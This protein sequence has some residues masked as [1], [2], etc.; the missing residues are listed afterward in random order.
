MTDDRNSGAGRRAISAKFST[1]TLDS[2]V[3]SS[4]PLRKYTVNDTG[5]GGMD[6]SAAPNDRC[7]SDAWSVLFA[8]GHWGAIGRKHK[9]VEQR[10]GTFLLHRHCAGLAIGARQ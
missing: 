5:A 8:G 4:L 6:A 9:G 7:T 10:L 1:S 2:S 3:N